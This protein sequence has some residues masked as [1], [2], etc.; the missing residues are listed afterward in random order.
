MTNASDHL[1][2]TLPAAERTE[3]LLAS[4]TLREKAFS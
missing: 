3:R 4:M 2:A 1:D